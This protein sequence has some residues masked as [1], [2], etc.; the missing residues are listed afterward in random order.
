MINCI[1]YSTEFYEKCGRISSASLE[2]DNL[3]LQNQ[4]YSFLNDYC[5]WIEQLSSRPEVVLYEQA[6]R[7]YESA[8]LSV[9]IGQYRQAFFGLRLCLELSL[10]GVFFSSNELELRTWISG[11]RDLKWSEITDDDK[12]IFSS[13]FTRAFFEELIEKGKIYKGIAE[14]VYRECSEFVHGNYHATSNLPN[15]IIFDQSAFGIWHE[16]A[17]SIR[18]VILYC[19]VCRYICFLEANSLRAVEENV[20]EELGHL[21]AVRNQYGG[22]VGG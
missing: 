13:N 14:K 17:K 21:S 18:L 16:K 22:T 1:E 4:S 9:T 11:K 19:F 3:I 20:L 7:E 6:C 15:E 2:G 10:G 8:F 5:C 12:G